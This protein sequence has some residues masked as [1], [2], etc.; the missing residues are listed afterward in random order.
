MR[1]GLVLAVV[2]ACLAAAVPATAHTA[3]TSEP[4]PSLEPR[5]TQQLYTRLRDR[6]V[7]RT[8]RV[9]ADCRPLRAVFYAASDWLRLATRLAALA[10]RPARSTSSPSRRSSA[11][12]RGPDRT[13]RRASAPSGR[14]STRSRRSTSPRGRN[15]SRRTGSSWYQAGVEARRRM[16]AAGFDVTAGRLLGGQRALVG[17][18]ARRRREAHGIRDFLRGLYDA[19]GEGPPTKGVVFI[20]GI[21]QRVGGGRDVQGAHA[22]VAPGRRVLGRREPV[23]QRLVAGGLRRRPRLRGPRRGR[24]QPAGTRSSTTCGTPDLLAVAGGGASGTANAFFASTSAPVANAAWQWNASFGWTDVSVE[25]MQQYVSAQVYALRNHSVRTGQPTDHWG[26][27]WAPRNHTQQ[28]FEIF[29]QD[30]G[31]VLDRLAQAIRDS[32]T[33]VAD[34]PGVNACADGR[35]LRRRP[36]GRVGRHALARLPDLVA[37]HAGLHDPAADRR[38]R[39]RLRRRSGSRCRSR[40]WQRSR[41]RP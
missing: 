6:Q 15:G 18:P 41:S 5:A 13:R 7:F 23:R 35:L 3:S 1:R 2:L 40:A 36:R 33:V 8:Y 38:R 31:I 28:A 10:P 16:V 26:F 30:T 22:G 32:Q 9:S 24:G 27:A 12:R 4:V 37:D 14:S 21:G 11:R 25:L 20:V 17:H 19:G 29:Q 39:C 34:D